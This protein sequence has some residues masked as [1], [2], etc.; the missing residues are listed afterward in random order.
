VESDRQR[1]IPLDARAGIP[2]A[3]LVNLP[4]D[5]IDIHREPTA[6]AYTTLRTAGGLEP[7]FSDPRRNRMVRSSGPRPP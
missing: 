6:G 4:E 1:K 5:G 7:Q 3:W 2:E